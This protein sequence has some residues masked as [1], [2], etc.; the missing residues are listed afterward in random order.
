[1]FG[2]WIKPVDI[3][4]H[5]RAVMISQKQIPAASKILHSYHT[6]REEV[7]HALHILNLFE[8]YKHSVK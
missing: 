5:L 3:N 8:K 1:M 2:K 6:V 7:S 4:Y